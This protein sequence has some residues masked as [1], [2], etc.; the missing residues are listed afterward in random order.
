MSKGSKRRPTDEQAYGEN[1]EAIFGKRPIKTYSPLDNS[2]Y[3]SCKE[4]D[5]P[6]TEAAQDRALVNR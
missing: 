5:T 3:E 4:T 1:L 6:R 2:G